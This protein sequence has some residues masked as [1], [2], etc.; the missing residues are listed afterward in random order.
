M[1][2]FIEFYYGLRKR[3]WPTEES[4]DFDWLFASKGL[5]MF[6]F[7]RNTCKKYFTSVYILGLPNLQRTKGFIEGLQLEVN[8]Q[9]GH[10]NFVSD[11]SRRYIPYL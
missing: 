2:S 4:A 7:F 5:L 10:D 6:L 9:N 11:Y 1:C 8:L 3:G